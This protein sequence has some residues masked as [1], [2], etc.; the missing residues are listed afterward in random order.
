MSKC[1]T[2]DNHHKLRLVTLLSVICPSTIDSASLKILLQVLHIAARQNRLLS[3]V[4]CCALCSHANVPAVALLDTQQQVSSI[5]H[6]PHGGLKRPESLSR[7][8]TLLHGQARVYNLNKQPITTIHTPAI[9]VDRVQQMAD[10]WTSSYC[11]CT[12][13]Q[14]LMWA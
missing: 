13:S 4:L 1:C 7:L 9:L 14:L 5:N 11:A 10:D 8:V 3:L 12:S 2:A 6:F